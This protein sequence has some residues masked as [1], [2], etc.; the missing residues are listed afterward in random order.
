MLISV[1]I[2]MSKKSNMILLKLNAHKA[3]TIRAAFMTARFS[4]GTV[5]V[6]R[7]KI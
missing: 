1:M 7:F 6:G 3:L 2:M 4:L 5:S